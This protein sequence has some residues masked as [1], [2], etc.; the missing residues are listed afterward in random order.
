MACQAGP[1]HPAAAPLQGVWGSA[2]GSQRLLLTVDALG[3]RIEMDC[4]SGVLAGPVQPDG[5]GKFQVSG[6]FEQHLAGPQRAGVAST[7]VKAR[8]TGEMHEGALTLS[9]LA[10]GTSS[11]QVFQLREG[12]R[13]KLIR[14][15]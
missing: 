13:V 11:P 4:A 9:I 1:T 7:A 15:L 14:C 6:T 12:A 2:S 3:G 10:E 5:Q 8:F